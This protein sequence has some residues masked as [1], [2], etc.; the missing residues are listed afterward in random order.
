M[1]ILASILVTPPPGLPAGPAGQA[2][3]LGALALCAAGIFHLAGLSRRFWRFVSIL[4][5]ALIVLSVAL[6]ALVVSGFVVAS[7]DP[8]PLG[9]IGAFAG[10]TIGAMAAMRM[11]RRATVVMTRRRSGCANAPLPRALVAGRPDDV[12][13]L[14]RANTGS[15]QSFEPAGCLLEDNVDYRRVLRGV[16]VHGSLGALP[17]ALSH[18]RGRALPPEMLVIAAQPE[19]ISDPHYLALSSRARALGLKVSRAGSGSALADGVALKAFDLSELLGRDPALLDPSVTRRAIS[20][21]RV[22]V[23]GAG[24][25]IGS[26]LVRQAAAAGPAEIVLL[27][28]CEFAL[29][30]IDREIS[31]N[32]PGV[33]A[34]PLLCDIRDRKSVLAAFRRHKPDLVYHAAALKHVPLVELNPCAG[35]TTNVFGTKNVAD[36]AL[37]CGARAMVQVSTDKAVDPVGMMGA[38]KRAGELYCQALDLES[39]ER[40]HATRFMTV[41]FG[42]VL[43]S[44][45]S[46]V[47][48]F[49]SQLE[50]GRPL[51]V[52]HPD[53]KRF[54]MTVHEAV[55]LILHSS[56]AA[57]EQDAARGRIFVL[58]MGEP[59]KVMTI[60][61]RM[62]RLSGL[63]PGLDV[64]IE[65][66]GLRPGEKLFEELFDSAERKLASAISGVF[67]AEPSPLPLPV[68]ERKLAALQDAIAKRDDEA[69]RR[70]VFSLIAGESRPAQGR[71]NGAGREAGE[72]GLEAAV[73]IKR[74]VVPDEARRGISR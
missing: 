64:P 67:E 3:A 46:V 12:E 2:A 58:D 31:E 30:S 62:I 26:E 56:Q 66:V 48:L 24:G 53:M 33:R 43:G 27:E 22:L 38:T 7:G 14:L 32:F 9:F 25:S 51:T 37:R 36:A 28:M 11:L 74:P 10:L 4:D 61:E 71:A 50:D 35:A 20:G 54:F 34:V 60:A 49:K 15:A 59:I 40:A 18:L 73:I 45:G 29:Y 57:F 41:R 13:A 19:A 72:I 23:T 16:P 68:I 39:A 52:T 69:A 63:E 21:R 44:S 6:L 5:L 1:L 42:N 17:A 8:L 55:S 65:I 47:P 70:A